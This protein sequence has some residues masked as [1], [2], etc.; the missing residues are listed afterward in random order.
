MRL[1]MRLPAKTKNSGP[2]NDGD[3][4]EGESAE[5]IDLA[6]RTRYPAVAHKTG[7]SDAMGMVAGVAIV[8]ALGAVTLWS[9]NSA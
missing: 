3:P 1:A 6:S 5:I 2:A 8:A 7:K 9:M 4:R